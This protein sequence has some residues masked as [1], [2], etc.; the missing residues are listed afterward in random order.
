MKKT[1]LLLGAVLALAA[2][3]KTV[4]VVDEDASVISINPVAAVTRGAELV[5][6]AL[7]DDCSIFV[8]ASI[9]GGDAT[10]KKFLGAGGAGYEFAKDGDVWKGKDASQYWPLGGKYVDFLTYAIPTTDAAGNALATTGTAPTV[11][12]DADVPANKFT[13]AS[14]NTYDNQFDFLYAAANGYKNQAA[15]VPLEF[16]HALAL[17]VVNVRFN[18]GG[19]EFKVTNV[20]FGNKNTTGVL[21]VNNERND[22]ALNWSGLSTDDLKIKADAAAAAKTTLANLPNTVEGCVKYG[23]DL[24]DAT[25]KGKFYQL[26]ETLLVI[27]QAGSN[28]VITFTLDNQEYVYEANAKRLNWEA[29][30]AYIYDFSF[31]NNEITFAP[32]VVDWVVVDPS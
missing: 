17:I 29:G 19:G 1:I 28:P 8:G 12:F 31:N 5:G 7:P 26:G 27:P 10:Q 6:T 14:W 11:T 21:E 24:D 32:T 2:C 9:V 22:I 15:A 20:T 3:S 16:N 25:H 23:D 30:K 13:T 18:T 4:T